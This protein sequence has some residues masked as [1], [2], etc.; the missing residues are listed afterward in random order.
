MI[1]TAHGFRY[2]RM[3]PEVRRGA[4][5]WLVNSPAAGNPSGTGQV[6][7][8][9]SFAWVFFNSVITASIFAW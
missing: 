8:Q 3:T 5:P 9:M 2:F 4:L 6:V 7:T 1:S